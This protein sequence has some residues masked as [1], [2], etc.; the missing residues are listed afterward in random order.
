MEDM[1]IKMI[2]YIQ[3]KSSYQQADLLH[4]ETKKQISTQLK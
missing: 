3:P 1:V 2:T 4:T